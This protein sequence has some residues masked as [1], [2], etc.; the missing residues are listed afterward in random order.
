MEEWRDQGIVLSVR[1]HGEGGG[2]AV[3]LTETHGK[4]AGY[5]YGA[6]SKAQRANLQAG[7]LVECEWQ[8]RVS[9]HLGRF[10]LE[11]VEILSPAILNDPLRLAVL[12]SAC[13]LCAEA[14][15]ERE[16]SPE[17]FH[18]LSALITILDAGN[19]VLYLSTYI[20]WEIGL[21]RALGFSLDLTRCAG[22]GDV[23]DLSYVSPKSGCAVS[24][25]KGAPYKE[26]L[27][28]LP[29]FLTPDGRTADVSQI[30]EGITLTGY[31]LEHWAFTHHTKGVPVQR[32]ELFRKIK[33]SSA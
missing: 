25:E 19:A 24:R 14:L 3:L 17:M 31:F 7:S 11:P 29:A 12:Q 1:P 28:R 21:L 27:L 30:E 4:A 5:V 10:D 13:A 16:V 32:Q 33:C 6:Q 15:P 9:E 8:A 22:G 23:R 26:K 2:V 18:A 20:K